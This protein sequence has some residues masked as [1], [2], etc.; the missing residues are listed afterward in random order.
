[1]AAV[2]GVVRQGGRSALDG[3]ERLEVLAGEQ[4]ELTSARADHLPVHP[5]DD[6][7]SPRAAMQDLDS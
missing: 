1:L 3:V 2:S 4:H 6:R 7:G 5:V